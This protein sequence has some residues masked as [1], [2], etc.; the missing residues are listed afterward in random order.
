M[1]QVLSNKKEYYN[2][3]DFYK[4]NI[5]KFHYYKS[6][7][8]LSI[9]EYVFKKVIKTYF[10]IIFEKLFLYGDKIDINVPLI[11][12]SFKIRRKIQTR[13][14]HVLKDNKESKIQGKIVKYKIPIVDDYYTTIIWDAYKLYP[15]RLFFS[16][17]RTNSKKKFV[18]EKGI[19][20]FK[21]LNVKKTDQK[22]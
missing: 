10:D 5:E 16:K 14:Y 3:K 18:S 21:L 11:S 20:N 2:L 8:K 1:E 19:E 12:G 17:T 6:N 4:D 15:V 7:K 9:S 13:G 22:K